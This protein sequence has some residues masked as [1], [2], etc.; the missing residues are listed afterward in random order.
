MAWTTT[1]AEL[2]DKGT[3]VSV[4]FVFTDSDTNQSFKIQADGFTSDDQIKRFATNQI[5]A[6]SGKNQITSKPNDVLDLSP[7]APPPPTQDQI[8]R[9]AYQ[10]L[11]QQYRAIKSALS[12][13]ILTQSDLDKVIS[14]L[15]TTYQTGYEVYL[16]GI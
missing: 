14:D 4:V 6:Y 1:I 8:D 13:G 7:P 12:F 10:A 16:I 9:Q 2:Q 15:K 11:V 5:A 3:T